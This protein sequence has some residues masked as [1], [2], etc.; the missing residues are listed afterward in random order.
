VFFA[1]LSRGRPK[2]VKRPKNWANS[3]D[4]LEVFTQ[5]CCISSD[6][7]RVGLEFSRGHLIAAPGW[8]DVE[9]LRMNYAPIDSEMLPPEP[10]EPV[11]II[12][13]NKHLRF[14]YESSF[15]GLDDIDRW[16][17]SCPQD[18]VAADR[19][20]TPRF[21]PR[22]WRAVLRR[23]GVMGED[24][25]AKVV[26]LSV[27][28]LSIVVRQDRYRLRP[29]QPQ[30]GVLLGPTGERLPLRARITHFKPWEHSTT[31]KLQIGSVFDGFGMVN[32]ARL[33]RLIASRRT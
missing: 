8:P 24:I 10:G 23:L 29:E 17:L 31:P 6:I 28:G 15:V 25:T 12:A 4:Q 19:R 3:D 32:H 1:K 16:V 2:P 11:R 9:S 18:I 33:A 20:S 22:G 26:D 5:L 27:G 30:V 21:Q 13:E 7:S 14:E